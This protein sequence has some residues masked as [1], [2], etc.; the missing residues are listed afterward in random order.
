VS[1]PGSIRKFRGERNTK[2]NLPSGGGKKTATFENDVAC[3]VDLL[4]CCSCNKDFECHHSFEGTK[5][6]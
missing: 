2:T 3:D 5:S 4:I 6:A 1:G